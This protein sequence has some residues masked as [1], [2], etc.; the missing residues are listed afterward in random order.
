MNRISA[1][2]PGRLRRWTQFGILALLL[3]TGVRYLLWVFHFRFGT[4]YVPRPASVEAFLPV[5]ALVS[6]K[7]WVAT[8]V[9]PT[10]HPAALVILIAVLLTAVVFHRGMCSWVC[11]V[12]LVEEYLGKL[13]I[14]G[15]G[16]KLTPPKYLDIPL[17]AVKYLL[18]A[19]FVKVVLVDMS[20]M[21]ALGFE[22]STYNKVA[23]VKMLDF[24]LEPGAWTIGIT[25]FLVVGSLFVQNFWCRY[26]CPYG[27]LLSVIGFV[28]PA[29]VNVN[30]DEAAC[31]DC[32]LCTK[33]CPN[34]VDV[35][36]ADQVR[37]LECTRCSQCIEACPK[38]ALEYR[39]GP[40]S[41]TP[42]QVG[43]GI[44]AIIFLVIGLAI[45][46][47]NWQSAV[48]YSEWARLVPAADQVGHAGY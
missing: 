32:G 5:S 21:A 2:E 46:T 14:R 30:R 47:G 26:L 18:L 44:V 38:G 22:Q 13:G 1:I 3:F 12:G 39:V 42:Q 10:V 6:L 31:D 24:W 25:G 37:A 4:P 19:F 29:S 7:G 36:S 23:A 16:R 35:Q 17:R 11:P 20:G 8:G 40:L 33:A 27:A 43:V 45:V 9:F 48:E 15:L 28:S 41:V 34:Y